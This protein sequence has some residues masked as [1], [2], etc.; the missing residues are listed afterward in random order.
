MSSLPVQHTRLQGA[1]ERITRALKA[2]LRN[3]WR[4][5]SLGLLALLAGWFFGQNLSSL[6]MMA[7][8]G[9]R[10][11]A[12]LIVVLLLEGV[13]RLRGRLV[14]GDPPMAWL[15]VDNFRLGLVYSVV[16]EA[17]KLGS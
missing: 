14:T 13:V 16:V 15:L 6:L 3:S 17:F 12:V 1:Q 9:G 4:G 8:P 5:A 2:Q 10:P 11:L 7:V